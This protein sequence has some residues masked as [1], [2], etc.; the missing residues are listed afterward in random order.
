MKKISAV[1]SL[2]TVAGILSLLIMTG[3]SIRSMGQTSMEYAD[4]DVAAFVADLTTGAHDIY[5]LST[6]GGV[7][8]IAYPSIP[9]S[10]VIRGKEGL[11]DRPVLKNTANSGSANA[12]IR[13]N[14]SAVRDTVVFE[15]LEFDGSGAATAP[16]IVRSDNDVHLVFRNCYLH[17]MLNSNGAVR[18][19]AAGTSLLMENS[20]LSGGIQRIIHPYTTGER[21]GDMTIRNCTFAGISSG[22]VVYFRSASGVYAAG[23]NVTIDHCTFYDIGGRITR[24]QADSIHGLV[25][26]TNS[27]FEQVTGELNADVIDFNYLAGMTTPPAGTNSI[28]TAPVFA[29]AAVLNFTLV[30]RDELTG[31]DFQILGDLSWY[32]DLFPPR[33]YGS[34]LKVDDT[35]VMVRFNEM[36]EA[37]SATT[38]SHYTLGGTAGLTGN[39]AEVILAAGGKEVTLTV[40]DLSGMQ[41]G[42]TV[43]VTVSGVTDIL[44]NVIAGDNVATY[45]LLDETPPEVTMEAQSV[46]NDPGQ[47]AVAR[48]SEPGWIYLVR[49]DV[50]PS[51]LEDL[52]GAVAA[53]TGSVAEVAAAG[54]D[55]LIPT[56][57]L[58][59]GEYDAYAVDEA[60]NV[61]EKSS[62]A[63]TVIEFIPRVRYYESSEAETLVTDLRGALD[64]DVFILTTSGGMYAY[65][66]MADITSRVTIMADED[67]E[68]R[69]VMRTIRENNTKQALRLAGDGASITVKGIEFN[70]GNIEAGSWPPKYAIR[71]NADIGRYT[72]VAEDCHFTGTWLANDGSSGAA[73][74][75]YNGTHADSI[76]FRNCIFEGDEG[77]V[78]NNTGTPFSWEWFEITN[79][80]FMNIPDDQAILIRQWG[81][82][83]YNPLAIDHCSFYGVGGT[84][85]EVIV[86]DSLYGVTL[87]NSIFGTTP[88]DTSWHLWGDGTTRATADY[89]DFFECPQPLT[90]EGGVLGT[91]LWNDDPQFADPPG[92]DLTLGNQALYSL[93]SD[94]LPLGDLRWADI[95]GPKVAGAMTA[96]SDS[97]LLL[98]FDEWIDTATAVV[99]SS[100]QL[101]GS[102]GLTGQ[103]RKAELFNFRSVLLTVESFL[104]LAGLEITVTVAGVE[105]LKGN[106]VDPA[107][108]TASYTVEEFRPVV[109]VDAQNVTNGT[110][111]FVMAQSNQGGG[112]L[113]IVLEGEPQSTMAELDAAVA[114]LKGARSSV[115]AAYT[116]TQID[117]YGIQPGTYHAYAVDGA[118]NLS[119]K[120]A[121]S[122]VV[123][124]G[125]PPVV[126]CA[127]QSAGNGPS[128]YV[129][130]QSSETGMLYIILDGEKQQDEN[131][132]ISATFSGKG[133]KAVVESA[134]TDVAVSTGGLLPGIYFAY[135]VDG[136]GNI[137]EKSTNPLNVTDATGL[138]DA[139]GDAVKVYSFNRLVIV[140]NAGGS[141]SR[142]VISDLLGRRVIDRPLTGDREEFRMNR[143]GVYIV[144][145]LNEEGFMKTTR[146]AVQ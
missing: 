145:L 20:L 74:K 85:E 52:E 28:T 31:G 136:A 66:G 92:G 107:R 98:K 102:A 17:D 49:G 103:V 143:Q 138:D 76:I 55:V 114:A 78:L 14:G 134:D 146:V 112:W 116:G 86:T 83:R 38:T 123:T 113:Y 18:M 121:Q 51:S 15:N 125:I 48:S 45:T 9:R 105:D 71:T 128:G 4:T 84:D 35:H 12:I 120:G 88:A 62:N 42:Q 60:G 24:Y 124:D 19:N 70:S 79:C 37:V 40:G 129:V 94:G 130:A 127:V 73:V 100:Y 106:P 41:V 90:D 115:S 56:T 21:Y 97:T 72:L 117:V 108:N 65:N 3:F 131:D 67:L 132:F 89:T 43:T 144:S 1:P 142:V 47:S 93:G 46:T 10:A 139:R 81:E 59:P 44:G 101:G 135:A 104:D 140:E 39:P 33:V 22:D 27:I 29:D 137:S 58:K 118:G 80:T 32:E 63:V 126:T 50:Q 30:N 23:N 34:L 69:P 54:E 5:I 64:G 25:S 77:I 111:Q 95:F 87:T 7:Y 99:A 119:E 91:N 75:L 82:N 109:T 110:G 122:I 68:E 8:D 133:E 36:V 2:K 11:A 57:A 16:I 53:R 13:V 6:S 26:V 96:R 141:F 61:S